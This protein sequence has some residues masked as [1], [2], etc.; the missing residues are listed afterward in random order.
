MPTKI[1]EETEVSLIIFSDTPDI[2]A[3]K[4]LDLKE[5]EGYLLDLKDKSEHIH[6]TYFDTKE[7]ALQAHKISLRIRRV[8]DLSPLITLKGPS[9]KTSYS[10]LSR[11]EIEK[12]WSLDGFTIVINEL[13]KRIPILVLQQYNNFDRAIPN[14][15]IKGIGLYIIQDRDS[16]RKVKNIMT[17]KDSSIVAELVIDYT[18]YNLSNHE[19]VGYYN[20]EI[21]SKA[22]NKPVDLTKY[23]VQMYF[24]NLKVWEHSK[25]AT[26]KAIKKFQERGE[27]NSLI[28][29]T[30]ILKPSAYNKIDQL[31]KNENI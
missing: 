7:A 9:H 8:N 29:N 21:E 13:R 17:K 16:H 31:I 26:G 2:I 25:F 19:P 1:L 14:E 5:I 22:D 10:N 4:I 12:Q 30:N 28:T 6:D 3:T 24:P 23:L 11:I 18:F 15:V 20:I 27:L